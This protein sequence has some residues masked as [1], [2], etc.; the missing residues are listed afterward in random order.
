MSSKKLTP[1]VIDLNKPHTCD[2]C[3]RSFAKEQTLIHHQCEPKRRHQNETQP[4]VKLALRAYRLWWSSLH[5][6]QVMPVS[7]QQFCASQL[8]VIFVK[9][10]SWSQEQQVQEFDVWVNWHIQAQTPVQKWCDVNSY[11]AYVKHLL[12][13]E[14]H[15]QAVNRS[16]ATIC[17]W[18]EATNNAWHEFFDLA[19]V[20]QT[21]NWIK[22]GRI[23]AWLLYNAPSAARFLERCTPEQVVLIQQAAPYHVWKIRF[24][25]YAHS[26]EAVKQT[27]T[28]AGM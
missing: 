15:L 9:I 13:S 7:Y 20:N 12:L 5:P 26:A 27:L 18:A 24:L 25:R 16:L 17:H 28:E 2:Y 6:T 4:H 1:Q 10:G 3:Q 11:E 22:Q 23:S 8:Y 21:V 14:H 19:N